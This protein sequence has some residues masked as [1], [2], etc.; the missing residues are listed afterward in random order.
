MEL[1]LN[2]LYRLNRKAVIWAVFFA[3][4]YLLRDYFTLLFLT[5]ILAFFAY[6]AC[7][8]LMT[9]LRLGR[10]LTIVLIYSGIVC[11]YAALGYWVV[12]RMIVE[13]GGLQNNLPEIQQSLK[14][15]RSNLLERYPDFAQAIES[16]MPEERIDEFIAKNNGE[17][18]KQLP[19]VAGQVVR[20]GM[21]LL[22]AIF[23]SF[24]IL[25]D[26]ARLRLQV[27]KLS[28]S[29]LHDFYEQAAQPVV[30]F[31]YVVGKAMQAQ[32]AIACAN[33]ALTAVGLLLM[34]IPSVAMLT[35]IVFLCSFVPVIG[36]FIST[37]PIVMIALNTAGPTMA[38][39]AIGFVILIHLVE[40]Y[41]LNPLIYGK[42]L[43]L[44]P[45][46]V[47]IILYI[48]HHAFGIWGMML[49]VPVTYYVLH[50]ILKVPPPGGRERRRPAP[51][52]E[53]TAAA[54]Q[55]GIS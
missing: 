41:L 44:N 45:V 40:A 18:E 25:M 51:T 21:T 42:H 19:H 30:R 5:F 34:G 54:A 27:Q 7:D 11:A 12:P 9:R 53:A 35:T 26:I 49:G 6:P 2:R 46:L 24:L 14:G 29:R 22:A 17:I 55:G 15:L 36:V 37:T 31:G 20:F 8:F 50:D 39:I 4:I 23:F 48:G 52:G 38:M 10:S 47:L 43:K 13:L 33:T 32:A 28:D 16:H 1:S 3:L